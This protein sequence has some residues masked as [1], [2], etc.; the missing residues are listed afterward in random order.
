MTAEMVR[1]GRRVFAAVLIV[2]LTAAVVY[3]FQILLLVFAGIL[4][5]VLLRSAGTW[6]CDHTRLSIGWCMAIVLI[7]FGASFFGAIWTF[8]VQIASQADQLFLA[9]SEAYGEFH[10]KL[11]QYHVA[12]TLAAG[13]GGLDLELPAKAAASGMLWTTASTVMVLFLGLYLS[14]GPQLYTGLF[15]SFFDNRLRTRVARLLD[16]MGSALRWWLVGQLIAM[17]AVGVITTAGLLLIG[18]PMAISLGVLA[19]LLTFIPYVGAIVSAVPAVL[20]AFA[21]SPNLAVY[22]TLIYLVAH[23]VEGYIIVPIIQHRLVY[24]PPAMILAGQFLMQLFAG[25]VGVT[26]ATP[27]MV[28]GMVLVKKLYFR[29]DW[30][31]PNDEAETAA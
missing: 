12:G 20:L 8:G 25:G 5:A 13:A 29:Q 15:L 1:F 27:L 19:M 28:V 18:A 21:H 26:F 10:N 16:A 22:V 30:D 24:M 11:A 9:V 2:G 7:G 3:S 4:L 14:T 17:A 6:L 31:E 23:I